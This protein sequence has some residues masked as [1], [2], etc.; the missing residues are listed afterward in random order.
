MPSIAARACANAFSAAAM[1]AR[2]SLA[3]RFRVRGGD[4]GLEREDGAAVGSPRR[5]G[6]RAERRRAVAM[7]A[8]QGLAL[9][10]RS[11]IIRGETRDPRVRVLG[12]VRAEGSRVRGSLRAGEGRTAAPR[13][14]CGHRERPCAEAAPRTRATSPRRDARGYA[15]IAASGAHGASRACVR[16]IVPPDMRERRA[17]CRQ[18]L[19]ARGSLAS[20]FV[21]S[22]APKKKAK[23]A[24]RIK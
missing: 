1:R 16:D 6:A 3:S 12:E 23:S 10:P 21:S 14:R 18:S 4:G 15:R 2:S 11:E 8:L 24:L 5:V 19:E 17:T 13:R 9:E 20:V 7:K 22:S